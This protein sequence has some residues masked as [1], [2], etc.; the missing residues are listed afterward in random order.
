MIR[1]VDD[2]LDV[3]RITRGKIE[4]QQGDHRAARRGAGMPSTRA[5]ADRRARPRR[6]TS[7]CPT[8]AGACSTPTRRGWRRC[9]S[10]L[11]NNAAK[12]T[13]PGGDRVEVRSTQA[14]EVV[15]HRA[16]QRRR[17]RC[18][19][20]CRAS[21]RCSPGRA[22]RWSDARRPGH[23]A[24]A[25]EEPRRAAR[26]HGA[27]AKPRS[28]SGQCLQ[29]AA[30]A[31]WRAGGVPARNGANARHATWPRADIDQRRIAGLGHQP[32]LLVAALCLSRRMTAPAPSTTRAMRISPCAADAPRASPMMP[33]A[34]RR[35]SSLL[36]G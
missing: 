16:R 27:S 30:Y 20:C 12:Y 23:R 3:S 28:R 2:L 6:S 10:N 11:L 26:R 19:S 33:D 14:G 18:R 34:D 8:R 17:H 29:R 25:G 32:R 5:T 1:L 22:R 7:R 21:S 35:G 13:D 4:L 24:D 9:S 31:S 15:D 36:Q